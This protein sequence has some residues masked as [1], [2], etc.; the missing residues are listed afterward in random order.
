M[1]AVLKLALSTRDLV[2]ADFIC[3][4]SPLETAPT[5]RSYY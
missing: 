5:E 3:E 4:E 2:G 1:E